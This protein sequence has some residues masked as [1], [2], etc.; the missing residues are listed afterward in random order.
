VYPRPVA[1][2]GSLLA[3]FEIGR[4]L[5]DP[6]CLEFNE[7]GFTKDYKPFEPERVLNAV[8][9][10]LS[11]NDELLASLIEKYWEK[12]QKYHAFRGEHYTF[13]PSLKEPKKALQFVSRWPEFR[14]NLERVSVTFG[15]NN[16]TAYLSAVWQ[17]T[18]DLGK[19]MNNFV[20][21]RQLFK[22]HGGR[23]SFLDI[24][25]HLDSFGIIDYKS[26]RGV[27][28]SIDEEIVP[29]VADVPQKDSY[30]Q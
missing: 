29:F 1:G 6:Y 4:E 23:E 5:K 9:T 26:G 30:L 21:V 2:Y 24:S 17:A 11:N 13:D 14:K 8:L 20:L 22:E 10:L 27:D 19:R 3:V 12:V 15:Q 18:M 7:L 28:I 25:S 16:V